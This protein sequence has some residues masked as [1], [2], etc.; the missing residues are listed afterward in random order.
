MSSST[1]WQCWALYVMSPSALYKMDGSVVLSMSCHLQHH[2]RWQ[3]RP[4]YVI[5]NVIQDS[6]VSL[7]MSYHVIC[8]TIQ[9]G[10]IRL[11]PS[12]HLQPHTRWHCLF[13]IFSLCVMST[14][15]SHNMAMVACLCHF[16]H[17]TRWQCGPLYVIFIMAVLVC[18]IFNIIQD[19]GLGPVM[20]LYVIFIMAVLVCVIFNIIQDGGLGP[21]MALYVI[22]I[23]A[24]LVCVIF[25]IT[26]D[27]S[28]GLCHLQHHTRWQCW[29]VSSSTSYKMAVLVCVIFNIIQ[30]GGLGLSVLC[31]LQHHTRWQWFN[32]AQLYRVQDSFFKPTP[33]L[34]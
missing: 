26:Q 21:V 17:H 28:V 24:V 13:V 27:G 30:D 20:A 12:Y 1:R 22:F 29:S 18:V 33:T 6:S 16:Q 3:C 7:I 5:F 23:M 11:S 9:D 4:H 31:H 15:A 10:G 8:N 2:T 32:C 25:N 14:S 19:G 34:P